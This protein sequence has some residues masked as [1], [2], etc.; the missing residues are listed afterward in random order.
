MKMAKLTIYFGTILTGSYSY[1]VNNE[2]L[3]ELNN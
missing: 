1:F 2:T 3:L